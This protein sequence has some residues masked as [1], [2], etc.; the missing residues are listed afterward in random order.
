MKKKAL[1]LA[2]IGLLA[3]SCASVEEV[4]GIKE[5]NSV[6]VKKKDYFGVGKINPF[7]PPEL[8]LKKKQIKVQVVETPLPVV[9]AGVCS[10]AKI[11]CDA[12][13]WAKVNIPLT[14][15]YKGNLYD[16]IKLLE[17][18]YSLKFSYDGKV[19]KLYDYDQFE[20]EKKEREYLKS[21]LKD[22][23]P[24][25]SVSFVNAPL[26]EVLNTLTLMTGWT[27]DVDSTIDLSKVEKT[28]TFTGKDV[29][30]T[31]VLDAIADVYDLS[32]DVNPEDKRI[33][34]SAYVT[35][36]YRIPLLPKKLDYTYTVST[37][38]GNDQAKKSVTITETFWKTI[39]K[40]LKNYLSKDGKYYISPESGVI[41]VTDR[42]SVVAR[43]D[44]VMENTIKNAL[45][46]V[47]FRVAVYE[48]TFNRNVAT[49]INWDAIFRNAKVSFTSTGTTAYVLNWSGTGSIAGNPFAYLVK[50]LE[51]YG[52]VKTLYDNY[53]KT[54]SGEGIT[55][56]PTYDYRYVSKV[57]VNYL[58][59]GQISA[60][61]EFDTLTLGMQISL[62]PKR[63]NEEEVSFD[64]T[65]ANTS[66]V[67]EE[68]YT[69][70]DNTF[71]NPKLISNNRVSFSSILKRG[72]LEVLTGWKGYK[73]ESD[74]QGV[75]YVSEIPGVGLLAKSKNRKV[76]ISEFVVAI[77]VY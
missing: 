73:V 33:V 41:S 18:N 14:V 29:P 75:P 46:Q 26:K 8:E 70:G 53:V 17:K 15:N 23:L 44:R 37:K 76:T 60:E 77:Y 19:L 38:N 24:K 7:T 40:T 20:V 72:Q 49:G 65:V 35:R 57:T 4:K 55:I 48:V 61:P 43:I 6:P 52:K 63:I 9:M 74:N 59:N 50:L 66:L 45:S 13:T 68:T 51:Q 56:Y 71:T 34:F 54:K 5:I 31:S 58:N 39:E 12:K 47:S 42:P 16:F 10:Q 25:V 62:I 64:V 67:S 32:Y 21:T 36:V 27:I 30:L 28:F 11:N 3:S 1:S 22:Y 2:V 69:F